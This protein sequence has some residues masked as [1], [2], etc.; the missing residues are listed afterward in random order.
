M[1]QLSKLYQK[2]KRKEEEKFEQIIN[3]NFEISNLLDQLEII[4][5]DLRATAEQI[6]RLGNEEEKDLNLSIFIVSQN[7]MDVIS[8]ANR[9][10]VEPLTST[11]E[12]CLRVDGKI[13]GLYKKREDAQRVMEE[14]INYND[15]GADVYIIP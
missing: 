3:K 7:K 1:S 6:E 8:G 9:L 5:D 15:A 11:F 2:L 10:E 14:I 4:R 12:Y 13:F